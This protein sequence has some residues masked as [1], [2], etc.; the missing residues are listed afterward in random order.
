MTP[1]SDAFLESLA[2]RAGRE[3]LADALFT[4]VATAIGELTIVTGAAGIVR[5]GF[6]RDESLARVAEVLGS[7]VLRSDRELADAGARIAAYV[8][9]DLG[10]ELGLA[11]DLALVRSPFRRQVLEI[12]GNDVGRGR[13][14]SYGDL[15]ALAGNPKAAR[16]VGSACATN[17]IPLVVP[18][19]RVL[20]SSG[21][22][23]NYGL[24]GPEIKRR[25]LRLEGALTG[26]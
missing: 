19:H 3:G 15:A 10:G 21:R 4:S 23:G 22:V 5:I 26:E 11:F 18:C 6:E 20:P 24:G 14:V 13:T 8:E 25:L 7:R 17:P 16:A 2:D 9:G 1:L 12:L